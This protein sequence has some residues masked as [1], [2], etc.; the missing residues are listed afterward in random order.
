M[1]ET[2]QLREHIREV[3]VRAE[4]QVKEVRV[5]HILISFNGTTTGSVRTKT[6][7]EQTT[8]ALYAQ[9]SEGANFSALRRKYSDDP[10]PGIYTMSLD[11]SEGYPRVEM[12]PAFGNVGWR[13]EVGQVGVAAFAER[14]SPFGWHIIKRVE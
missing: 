13:L 1:Q 8:A 5:E 4:H 2:V 3:N 11:G 10:G 14:T 6:E 7:A 9:V 12:A